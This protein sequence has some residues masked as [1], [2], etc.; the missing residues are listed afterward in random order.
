[1]PKERPASPQTIKAS[2]AQY[3]G[4]LLLTVA[5]LAAGHLLNPLLGDHVVYLLLFPAIAFSAWYCGFGASAMAT[6][7]ALAGLKLWFVS[8]LQALTVISGKQVIVMAVF[9]TACAVIVVMGEMRHRESDAMRRAR[10]EL[11]ERVRERTAELDVANQGLR[12]LTAHLMQL[13][14]EERRRIARELHDSVGQMLAAL[15]MNLTS[16]GADLERLGQTARTILDSSTLVQ[17]MNKEVRTISHLLHPPL[18]DE[19]GLV[20]ALR[21]YI[22]GFT[23]RSKIEVHLEIDDNLGRFAAEL[24]TAVF[25]TVQECLTNVHRHSGS[26]KARVQLGHTGSEL[27]LR[28]EDHGKGIPPEKLDDRAPESLPGVGIR[29]MQERAR[30]L[31]GN[32]EITSDGKGTIIEGR[33]PTR[34]SVAAAGDHAA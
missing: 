19:A 5:A 31:G 26:P 28:V 21:W 14:D 8:P 11:E 9:F 3:A 16:V 27:R 34:A 24:E 6:L 15:S 23:E 4:A 10:G 29:G 2:V 22:E 30:Q 1:M 25:R 7:V 13:Q 20:S 18:L 32:L 33:F 17:E 12:E